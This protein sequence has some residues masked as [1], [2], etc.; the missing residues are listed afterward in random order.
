MVELEE[1]KNY[2]RVDFKDDDE[3]IEN[4]MAAA[5][6][7][8]LD[9]LRTDDPDVLEHAAN[10]NLAI[11]FAV[12]YIYENRENTDYNDLNLRLRALLFG[13]REVGF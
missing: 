13:D 9:V 5:E 8:C 2:L 12:A 4:L 11:M 6:K 10:G 1:M 7:Q 3:L